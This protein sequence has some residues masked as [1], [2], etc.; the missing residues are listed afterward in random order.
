M[1]Q[2]LLDTVE[3]VVGEREWL[4]PRM[5]V[6]VRSREVTLTQVHGPARRVETET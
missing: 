1:E 5:R 2:M 3:G 6:E 4:V